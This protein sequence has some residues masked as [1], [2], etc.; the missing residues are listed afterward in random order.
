MIF[1]IFIPKI[2][3]I[4]TS[5]TM[6]NPRDERK[7]LSRVKEILFGNELQEV[8]KRL[9]GIRGELVNILENQ[10]K[11]LEEKWALQEKSFHRKIEELKNQIAAE[12]E[13]NAGQNNTLQTVAAQ[14]K[15][16]EKQAVH[17]YE[18]QQ[19]SLVNLKKELDETLRKLDLMKVDKNE[20]ADLFGMMVQKLK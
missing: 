1:S 18:E 11:T 19:K 6:Q 2:C 3:P 12:K 5:K 14:I 13:V 9:E 15:T 17:R 10:I 16:L 4:I 7:E 20:I 8:D